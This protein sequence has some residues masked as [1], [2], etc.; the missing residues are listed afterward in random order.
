[1]R[2][3][4]PLFVCLL[5]ATA[6]GPTALREQETT[7]T[8]SLGDTQSRRVRTL[9][10]LETVRDVIAA[11][12]SVFVATDLGLLQYAEGGEAEVQRVAGLPSDDVRALEEDE[13]ALLIATGGGMVRLA[14]GTAAPVEG[15]PDVG[16]V[17]DMAR[18]ADGT[19]WICGLGGVARRT[20]DG[21][22][23]FGE[24]VHCTTLAP[25][26]EG[27][28]W[29]GT[30][31]GLWYVEGDVVREHPISGG[32]P[33]GYVR[34]VV[35]V[36]PG[37]I[38]ALVQGP[39][40]AK[41]A[42]WDGETWFGYTLPGLG[43]PAVELVR[44]GRDVLLLSPSRAVAIGP[45]GNG[46][47][48]SPLE[49]HE[50]TVRSFRARITPAAEH[51]PAE[52]ADEDVLKEPR[53]LAVIPEG[54][55]T[56][57]APSFSAQPVELELPGDVYEAFVD[58]ADAYL[59]IANGGVL[60]LRR[61]SPPRALRSLSLVPEEHLQV[62]TDSGRTV[63]MLSRDGELTKM[64]NGRLRRSRLPDGLVAQALATGP[65]GAVLLT[66]E[67]EAGP[68]VVR[69]FQNSGGGWSPLAQRTIEVPT[70]L[71]GVPFIGVAPDGKVWVAPRIQRE[72]G[73]GERMRGFAVID[74]NAETIVYHHRG[75]DREQGG[76][77]VPDEVSAIDFDTDG[78]AW[79]ASLSG[80]IRVGAAQ[81]VIFGEA[82]G[83]RGEV[84]SDVAVGNSVIWVA[85]AEGLGAYDRTRFDYGQP[86]FVQEA[87]P[88][89]L[90]TDLN[91]NLWA[92]SSHGLV[93]HRDGEWSILGEDAGLPVTAL[94]DV[95][96]DAADRVWLLAEDRVMVLGR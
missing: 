35:P 53:S 29:V 21:W 56:V 27:Q 81:A 15:V 26:P 94:R 68:G 61:S 19:L 3:V 72:N 50:G 55:P 76:L 22:E 25:T 43:G 48:L 92:A 23:A 86:A 87:R 70:Q 8:V 30:T 60:R 2:R 47:G 11:E 71:T 73:S 54:H 46:V 7:P 38:M 84:V 13:G 59:A 4:V 12:D 39:T 18:T 10:D 17:S 37:K 57:S 1:M 28:L 44:R 64:V 78:N 24:P 49:S 63:W 75:A 16:A 65:H 5:S 93:V 90:A 80:L 40:D 74:P 52:A 6:C 83:V 69:L 36:L 51:H 66:L 58:G 89:E 45:T 91:G 82:R 96:T 31:A 9:T 95:Q 79:V 88:T 20:S 34:S 14:D 42:Y 33:D 85:S 77:P 67:P 41:I 62:A 32:I